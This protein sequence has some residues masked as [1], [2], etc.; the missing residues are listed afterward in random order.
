MQETK[1]N[2]DRWI[3]TGYRHFAELGPEDMHVNQIAHEAGVSR[4]S[5]YQFF[6]DLDDFIGHLLDHHSQQADIYHA[7][8]QACQAYTEIF[9]VMMDFHDGVFFHRQLL[10][11][12]AHPAFH[13]LYQKLNQIGNAIVYPLWAEYFEYEGNELAGKEIHLMLIDLWYLNLTK[14]KFTVTAFLENSNEIR[15]QL[16]AY[17]RSGSLPGLA[18]KNDKPV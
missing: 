8:L 1:S 5:F 17:K 13:D 7:R 16:N 12:G 15:R 6:T 11:H 2:K 10:L 9:R 14:D 3:E 4:T 18:Q